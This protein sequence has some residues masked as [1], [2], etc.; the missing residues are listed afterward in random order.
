MRCEEELVQE[1]GKTLELVLWFKEM[2]PCE[3]SKLLRI[4]CYFMSLIRCCGST[5]AAN[6]APLTRFDYSASFDVQFSL[7]CHCWQSVGRNASL[8]MNRVNILDENMNLLE[9]LLF[10]SVIYV[11]SCSI[12]QK[13]LSQQKNKQNKQK[14]PNR[15][16]T[17]K[18]KATLPSKI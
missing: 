18:A 17:K 1:C 4:P 8:W 5:S 10:V 2:L 9:I 12:K 14:K 3:A 16:Q 7:S 15:K 11:F 6:W 13:N